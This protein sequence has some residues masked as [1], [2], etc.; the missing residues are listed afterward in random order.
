MQTTSNRLATLARHRSFAALR[1]AR[2]V[3]VAMLAALS[4]SAQQ[5]LA[6]IAPLEAAGQVACAPIHTQPDDEG[7]P[8]GIWA[9]GRD[10]KASFAGGMAF[11][12]YLGASADAPV[13]WR[14]TTTS[15]TVGEH[16][17]VTMAPRLAHTAWRAEYDLG[18]L[19][20]AYDV[21]PEGLEQTFVLR[22]RPATNGELVIRGAVASALH[23]TGV[24]DDGGVLFV[25]T[26]GRGVVHYGSA[27]AIDA[28]GRR[29]P[30]QTQ[31]VDGGLELRLD[32]A[33][34]AAA[35][36]PVVVDPLVA[37][38]SIAAGAT[39]V[40]VA[41]AH[42]PMGTK[43]V[44]YAECRQTGTDADLRL[45]RCDENGQNPVLVHSDI[46]ASWSS[47]EPS[48]GV[49]VPAASTVLA[50]T[51]HIVGNDTRRVRAHVHDR[52]DVT[53]DGSIVFLPV[54]SDT[55]QWRPTVGHELSPVS[56]TSVLIAYQLEN[57]VA[58]ANGVF[59]Q[60]HAVELACG[61]TGSVVAQFPVAAT[62]F[63]DHER[64]T[65]AKVAVGPT[66]VWTVGYQRY[67][68]LAASDWSIGLRR[69]DAANVVGAESL[70][71]NG[72][73]QQHEMAPKLGG[74]DDRLMLFC[75]A[76]T[77]AESLPKPAG[78][79]G[80]RIRG[81]RLDWTGSYFAAPHGT[82]IL[83]SEA[84]ARLELGGCDFDRNSG[85]HW[86]LGF[87]S[88]AT[89]N[90]Y[91]GVYGFQGEEV[92]REQVGSPVTGLGTS[93]GGAVCFQANDDEFV[94]A[95]GIVDPGMNSV[96]WLRRSQ[97]PN[98]L[99][100]TASGASCSPVQLSWYGSTWIGTENCGL[101]FANAPAGSF[102]F[103]LLALAPASLQLF[104]LDGIHDGCWLHVP[105]AGPD[106]VGNLPLQLGGSGSWPLPLPEALGPITLRFQG[107]NFDPVANEF[108]STSRMNVPIT[109]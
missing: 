18:G 109:K 26:L 107:V 76:S 17:L 27:I 86:A 82:Q 108:F 60:I 70:V 57:S 10:Y 16:Q 63:V 66:R 21:R 20:E 6:P 96:S 81:L 69:I 99:G 77:I 104:G 47:I 13:A 56:F 79:N 9:A 88:N 58:F 75:T 45:F 80:H 43:N 19:V 93:V 53:F 7:Q 65:L 74:S 100:V 44:W 71:D 72:I 68:G 36:F 67:A 15:A 102:T 42:D 89:Q 90:V 103:V 4:L 61:G 54:Q 50:W 35:Q 25:D 46:T 1:A 49:N 29:R 101:Q 92:R 51:R 97:Y 94:A 23:A 59:S 64:P 39:V 32:A 83:E 34:L 38:V 37:P 33:W 30:M 62:G 87:R 105:I 24:G 73:A 52:L 31:L 95:Y 11:V 41:I 84:D 48:L 85:S 8:Y 55:H 5:Q 91:L 78:G 3:P 12:P 2:S 98:I 14:W 40:D 28:M 22:Q 106:Y